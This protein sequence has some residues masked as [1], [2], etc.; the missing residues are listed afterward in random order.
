M[1]DEKLDALRRHLHNLEEAVTSF[2][3]VL[4]RTGREREEAWRN[5]VNHLVMDF[6]LAVF[7]SPDMTP[8]QRET[9]LNPAPP[10]AP[11]GSEEE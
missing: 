8:E 1:E 11:A 10:P 2:G 7:A 6:S 9:W 3:E 4:E 5:I